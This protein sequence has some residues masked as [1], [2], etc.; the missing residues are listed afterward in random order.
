MWSTNQS[1]LEARAFHRGENQERSS[2]S[3]KFARR[4]RAW[5][6]GPPCVTDPLRSNTWNADTGEDIQQHQGEQNLEQCVAAASS[7]GWPRALGG[8]PATIA[9]HRTYCPADSPFVVATVTRG[10]SFRKL[11]SPT[12]RTFIRSSTFLND[13][14]FCRY[15]RM[16][17]AVDFPMPGSVSSCATLAVFRLIGA[18]AD[19]AVRWVPACAET[20]ATLSPVLP[21]PQ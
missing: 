1:Q 18:D 10:F 20:V 9:A 13:P 5:R 8:A 12:P 3:S 4:W 14:F 6:R 17:S 21:E 7:D 11:F 16:R 15:S 2:R 19:A